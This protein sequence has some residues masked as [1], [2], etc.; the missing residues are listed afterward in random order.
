MGPDAI[1][2]PG[3]R[4]GSGLSQM[5]LLM[6]LRRMNPEA[7]GE[8][9]RWRDARTGEPIT[10]HGFRSSFRDWCG[11]ASRH[12]TDLAEAALAHINKLKAE[13]AY[14]RGDLFAKRAA[15]MEDWAMFCAKPAADVVPLRAIQRAGAL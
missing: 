3:Q 15:L 8:P 12:P 11:E 13:A 10:A 9:T 4:R 1:V 14:A 6:L 7:E 2:F 5:A